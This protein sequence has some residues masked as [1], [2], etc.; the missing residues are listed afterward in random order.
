M[1]FSLLGETVATLVVCAG[2][3]VH[4]DSDGVSLIPLRL[5]YAMHRVNDEITSEM[6][7]LWF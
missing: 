7:I 3:A 1:R 2:L 4:L 5:Y 6:L